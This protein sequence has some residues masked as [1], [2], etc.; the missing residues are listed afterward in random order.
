MLAV[1]ERGRHATWQC[2][3][4]TDKENPGQVDHFFSLFNKYDSESTN[5]NEGDAKTD[6]PCNGAVDTAVI[7]N[8]RAT[9]S[10]TSFT[11]ALSRTSS[12]QEELHRLSNP[13]GQIEMECRPVA[14]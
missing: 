1:S 2:N 9:P 4:G 3:A 6:P 5:L 11:T 7:D 13:G 12:D 10:P 8:L 14:Y